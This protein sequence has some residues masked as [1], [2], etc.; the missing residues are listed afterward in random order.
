M[1]YSNETL[2]INGQKKIVQSGFLLLLFF[3]GGGGVDL[4]TTT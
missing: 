2:N 1:N 4:I 3:F